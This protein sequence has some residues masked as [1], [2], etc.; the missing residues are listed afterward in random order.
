[1][2]K[3][4]GTRFKIKHRVTKFKMK[5][6][7]SK[8]FDLLV[9][10]SLEPKAG[11]NLKSI[12]SNS[13]VPVISAYH[14]IIKHGDKSFIKCATLVDLEEKGCIIKARMTFEK[15]SDRNQL[16]N[17][18][19]NHPNTN[20]IHQIRKEGGYDLLTEMLFDHKGKLD[21][22]VTVL[23]EKYHVKDKLTYNIVEDVKREGFLCRYN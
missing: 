16:L 1:L 15:V 17:F 2:I 7:G 14:Q 13:S 9:L 4:L 3:N 8:W 23:E 20:S 18:L 12:S 10:A 22:F 19:K 21:S 5:K 6:R 11:V